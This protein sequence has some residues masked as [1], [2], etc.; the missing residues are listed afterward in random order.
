M[1]E[2]FEVLSALL[3]GQPVDIEELEA[4]LNS[5]SGRRTLLDFARLRN[6]ARA[7][8]DDAPRP[9]FS[10][11]A[12]HAMTPSPRFLRRQVPLPA[13]AAAVILAALLASA[14]NTGLFKRERPASAP[15]EATRV[16][17]FEPGVDWQTESR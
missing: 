12:R 11:K 13:A 14:L 16:L 2:E 3:D 9:E 5:S 1:V 7:A 17:R 15:P 8:V 10:E 4:A 6:D